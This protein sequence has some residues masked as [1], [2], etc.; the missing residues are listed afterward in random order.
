M[1]LVAIVAL[2]MAVGS[3]PGSA[4]A[5][6]TDDEAAFVDAI[7]QIRVELGLPALE[8]L[9]ELAV[10]AREHAAEMADAG[11]IFHADPISAGL[12]VEWVKLGENVGVGAGIEVLIDAFVASPGHYANIIDP[13][14]TRIGVGVVWRGD[15]MYTTHRFLQPPPEPAGAQ[16]A[17][18]PAATVSTGA[19]TSPATDGPAVSVERI[20]ALYALLDD[21]S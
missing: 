9:P 20:E 14:F 17:P 13:S 18:A 16:I 4:S 5:D 2:V 12:T 10:T 1:L 11:E 21:V 15:S 7:N 8:P 19:D 6:S 3:I